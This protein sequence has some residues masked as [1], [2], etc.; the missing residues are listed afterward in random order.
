M[1]VNQN[2]TAKKVILSTNKKYNSEHEDL[3]AS[4]VERKIELFCA[5]GEDCENWEEALDSACFNEKGEEIGFIVTTS[6]P[7]ETLEEV[8]E[9]A[10]QW[11]GTGNS[12]IQIIKI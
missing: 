11:N 6:H 1:E 5:I 12:E 2:S 10:E 8:K 7:N 4:L 9:F 3:L